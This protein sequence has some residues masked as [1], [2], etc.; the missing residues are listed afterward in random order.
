MDCQLPQ[1]KP[2]CARCASLHQDLLATNADLA[3]YRS[4]AQQTITSLQ[5]RIARLECNAGM[6]RGMGFDTRNVGE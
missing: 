3:A 5:E 1:R 4:S 2:D 6:C